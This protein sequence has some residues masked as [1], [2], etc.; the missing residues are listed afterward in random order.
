MVFET[1]RLRR[2]KMFK[3]LDLGDEIVIRLKVHVRQLT[4]EQ[5]DVSG[6]SGPAV[7]AADE[8]IEFTVLDVE[9]LT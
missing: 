8:E 6:F 9:R 1:L 2:G 5:V 3:G 4:E 7:L